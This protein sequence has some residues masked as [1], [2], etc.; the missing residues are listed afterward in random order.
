[1]NRYSLSILCS[2]DSNSREIMN[3]SVLKDDKGI[4]CKA[5]DVESLQLELVETREQN[6]RLQKRCE[7]LEKERDRYKNE[8]IGL[9]K[10]IAHWSE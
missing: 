3:V 4:W 5:S 1:M 10:V 2:N 9:H 8:C 7:E 6:D